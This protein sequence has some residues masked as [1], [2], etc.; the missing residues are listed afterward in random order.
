MA[1][2][3]QAHTL[4]P[5]VW[6][7]CFPVIAT[8]RPSSRTNALAIAANPPSSVKARDT[9]VSK[10]R[11]FCQLSARALTTVTLESP[12]SIAAWVRKRVFLPLL[13]T[14]HSAHSGRTMAKTSPGKPPPEP[15]SSTRGPATHGNTARQSSRCRSTIATGSRTAVRLVTRFQR[16]NSAT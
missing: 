13:S 8:I 7:V 16:S 11:P 14:N 10:S 4:S 6:P 2:T 5:T 3:S 15:R 9:T 1:V 12:S